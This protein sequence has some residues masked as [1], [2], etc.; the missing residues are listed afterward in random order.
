[1]S[2]PHLN[3]LRKEKNLLH[4]QMIS[5]FFGGFVSEAPMQLAVRPF[6]SSETLSSTADMLDGHFW[7]LGILGIL[8]DCDPFLTESNTP[9]K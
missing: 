3:N 2:L 4:P 1:M 9:S 5:K 6:R 8:S 7:K